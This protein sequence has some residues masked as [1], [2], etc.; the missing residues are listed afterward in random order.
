[1]SHLNEANLRAMAKRGFAPLDVNEEKIVLHHHRQAPAG[2]LIEIH[3]PRHRLGN[4]AQHPFGTQRSMGLTAEQRAAFNEWR[5][6]YWK[7]RA[8][9]ELRRRGSQ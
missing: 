8:R 1:L 9:E 6:D 4:L 3:E 7:A 5:V 2:P